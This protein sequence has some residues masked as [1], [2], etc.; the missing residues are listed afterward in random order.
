MNEFREEYCHE[1]GLMYI[2]PE[3]TSM[4]DYIEFLENKLRESL[5]PIK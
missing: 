1:N 5:S 2:K 4:N 3:N